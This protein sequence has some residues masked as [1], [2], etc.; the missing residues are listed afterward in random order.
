MFNERHTRSSKIGCEYYGDGL[1]GM[2]NIG[3]LRKDAG[4]KSEQT[5]VCCYECSRFNSCPSR[6]K[7]R[8]YTPSPSLEQRKVPAT[9]IR[10]LP[11]GIIGGIIA[12]TFAAFLLR[13]LTQFTGDFY[14]VFLVVCGGIGGLGFGLPTEGD[15]MLR[16]II[17]CFFGILAIIVGYY[18]IYTMPISIGYL[19]VS[20]AEVMSFPEFLSEFLGPL[21]YVFILAGIV[22]AYFAGTGSLE[23]R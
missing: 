18:F 13:V 11:V 2:T 16:G 17:G 10:N 3:E 15:K 6:C 19:T 12:A 14:F 23:F 5:D 7:I 22:A 21:D 9:P 20:P 4:C 1:C 8:P